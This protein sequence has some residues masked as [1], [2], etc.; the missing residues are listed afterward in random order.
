MKKSEIKN[1]KKDK[2]KVDNN[3]S[4]GDNSPDEPK[5]KIEEGESAKQMMKADSSQVIIILFQAPKK[6]Y[7]N[8]NLEVDD[9]KKWDYLEHHGVTFPDP[10]IPKNIKAMYC[11]EEVG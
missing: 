7:E 11:H 8:T 10:Y 1:N 2:K 9:D 5:A 4:D 3:D 6:W